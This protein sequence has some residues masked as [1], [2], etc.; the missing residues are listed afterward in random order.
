M[1]RLSVSLT[2]MLSVVPSS[3][4][5]SNGVGLDC[6]VVAVVLG[7]TFVVDGG[8]CDGIADDITCVV[9]GGTF[10]VDGGG[11]DGIADDITCVVLGDTCVAVADG[12]IAVDG[13]VTFSV[14]IVLEFDIS[15]CAL[16]VSRD[17]SVEELSDLNTSEFENDAD[18]VV[19]GGDEEP[20]DPDELTNNDAVNVGNV[21]DVETKPVLVVGDFLSDEDELV[22]EIFARETVV[23][24]DT[25][26][27][28]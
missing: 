2:S 25:E 27:T 11:C 28:R 16:V 13:R 18:V 6:V 22:D 14:S 19:S 21:V 24:F 4:I 17:N 15:E 26:M 8:G 5:V 20:I 23:L 10:V 7:G 3:H 12:D 9:L 1:S